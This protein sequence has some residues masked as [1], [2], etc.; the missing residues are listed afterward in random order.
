RTDTFQEAAPPQLPPRKKPGIKI[1]PQIGDVPDAHI[2]G[3]RCVEHVSDGY[4]NY[5]A[6]GSCSALPADLVEPIECSQNSVRSGRSIS[7]KQRTIEH[8]KPELVRL[9][10]DPG[11]DERK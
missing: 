9:D 1:A 8:R 2:G 6:D 10:A 5:A 3:E 11:S 4:E 7:R